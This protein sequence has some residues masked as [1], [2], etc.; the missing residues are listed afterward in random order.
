[1][2][3]LPENID[4][5]QPR[6]EWKKQAKKRE[7]ALAQRYAHHDKRLSSGSKPLSPLDCGDIVAIQ[8]Q[9]HPSKS[10]RWTK[11]GRVLEVL[12]HDS[13]LVKIDG[14]GHA[15]QRNC[16]SI[17]QPPQGQL[18][19]HS[20][21][22]GHQGSVSTA[23]G[24]SH[25]QRCRLQMLLTS[26]RLS[27]FL[28]LVLT[29]HLHLPRHHNFAVTFLPCLPSHC[30]LPSHRSLAT[31]VLPSHHSLVTTSLPCLSD[32]ISLA[33]ISLCLLFRGQPR[34]PWPCS[35]STYSRTTR[36][37]GSSTPTWGTARLFG[38]TEGSRAG[39][40]AG[41]CL[42]EGCSLSRYNQ[43]NG[44]WGRGASTEMNLLLF[45]L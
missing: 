31:T 40:G 29:V 18:Y 2:T 1:M 43:I 22:N 10:G 21:T 26:H 37:C 38:F 36:S 35:A 11:T 12:G 27:G 7:T 20:S 8:D 41:D 23:T 3:H 6:P 32:H 16:H 13:Y 9:S 34:L 17:C 24:S 44:S 4:R 25:G 42:Q 39:K 15:I 45:V 28:L 14:S 5:Y 30:S 19:P 33:W